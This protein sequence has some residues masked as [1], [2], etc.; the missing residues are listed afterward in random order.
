LIFGGENLTSAATVSLT[1]AGILPGKVT[2]PDYATD[3]PF[4]LKTWD[5]KHPIFAAFSDPQLGDLSRLSFSARTRVEP[6]TATEVLATFRDGVPA[7]VEQRVGQGS[8]VWLAMAAD[9][10]SSDW[11]S[12]RLYLPLVYQ[13]I[14]HQTGLLAGGRVR[15]AT[16]ESGVPSDI[17][18]PPGVYDRDTYRLVVNRGPREAETDRCTVEEFA[19][20]FGLKLGDEFAADVPPGT[21]HASLGT[22]LIDSEIGP[23]LA[24]FLLVGLVLEGIVANRTVA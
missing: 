19:S 16:L 12:S 9:R 4:R 22:E 15:Q 23:W 6:A 5:T 17:D 14:G 7:F 2:G 11:T 13:L 24:G 1:A 8:V 3:L 18:L 21:Q 20:R 10:S